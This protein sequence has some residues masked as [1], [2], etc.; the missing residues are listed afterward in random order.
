MTIQYNRTILFRLLFMI[1]A[2]IYVSSATAQTHYMTVDSIYELPKNSRYKAIYRVPADSIEHWLKKDLD[3]NIDYINHLQPALIMKVGEN[4]DEQQLD[5]GHYVIVSTNQSEVEAQYYCKNRISVIETVQN[6][7]RL[8]MLFNNDGSMVDDAIVYVGKHQLKPL[9][10]LGGNYVINKK[11]REDDLIVIK[12]AN[13]TSFLTI[14]D[15]EEPYKPEFRIRN[16]PVIKQVTGSYKVVKRWIANGFKPSKYNLNKKSK[17]KGFTLFDKPLYKPADTV[18]VKFWISNYKEKPISEPLAVTLNYYDRNVNIRKLLDTIKPVSA[19]AY[20]YSLVITDS[21]P[22]DANYY[23]KL[24][25]LKNTKKSISSSFKTESYVLPDISAF[26]ASVNTTDLLPKDTLKITADAKD[27]NGLNL[28]DA[29]IEVRIL[30]DQIYDFTQYNYFVP[31]TLYQNISKLSANEPFILKIPADSLP[32][33]NVKCK[34]EV[35]LR[36]SNNEIKDKQF[37]VDLRQNRSE[38]KIT[39]HNDSIAI[40]Y[41]VNDISTPTKV[42]VKKAFRFSNEVFWTQLPA[43]IYKH[44]LLNNIDVSLLNEQGQTILNESLDLENDT[45]STV[46]IG[47]INNGDSVGFIV[48]NP[49]KVM[50]NIQIQKSKKLLERFTTKDSVF[51]FN[52]KGNKKHIYNINVYTVDGDKV[53]HKGLGNG[54]FA[55]HLN[56]SVSHKNVIEPGEKDTINVK[57]TDYKNKPVPN[58]N[59]TALAQN[60]QLKNHF[61]FPELPLL[62]QFKKFKNPKQVSEF[63]IYDISISGKNALKNYKNLRSHLRVDTM[64]FYQTIFTDSVVAFKTKLN[65]PEPE[66]WIQPVLNGLLIDPAYMNV[67]ASPIYYNGL[68]TTYE[69]SNTVKQG[70]AKIDIRTKWGRLFIDSLYIQPYYKHLFFVN[71][72]NDYT[73]L[74]STWLSMPDSLLYYEKDMIQ[75]N[76]SKFEAGYWHSNV[77]ILAN[78]KVFNIHNPNVDQILGPVTANSDLHAYRRDDIDF[79]FQFEPAYRYRISNKMA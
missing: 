7:K 23:L 51:V 70:F 53:Q 59:I 61:N 38:I 9:K 17:L 35:W 14:D 21:M 18:N 73:P 44:P 16:I 50:M 26:N 29:T 75:N 6:F 76:F 63:E 42:F 28:L 64:L 40:E 58:A 31:D 43:T 3:V 78:K 13:D 15:V 49:E 12:S 1:F 65:H 36:N 47:R 32:K 20:I 72:S 56:V 10:G 67:N 11:I 34:V 66:I 74:N 2:F 30:T 22:N 46:Q 45:K 79:K 54:V 39:P 69:K 52:I 60:T 77:A 8:L 5:F 27:A 57:I 62:Y 55:K 68:N 24:N 25:S 41:L 71:V 4:I 48:S 37:F 19:G 33:I